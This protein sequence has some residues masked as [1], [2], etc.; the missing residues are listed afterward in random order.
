MIKRRRENI[1]QIVSSARALGVEMDEQAD[2]GKAA[3]RMAN[4][5]R[6][7]GRIRESALFRQWTR[8]HDSML[9]ANI[10]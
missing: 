6:L 3:K 5:S 1:G 10:L 4:V 9:L 7:T 8:P 2:F